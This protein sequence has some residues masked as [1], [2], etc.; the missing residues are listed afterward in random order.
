MIDQALRNKVMEMSLGGLSS[1]RT[2]SKPEKEHKEGKGGCPKCQECL[3]KGYNYCY[4][5][6]KKLSTKS[7]SYELPPLEKVL[8]S[9]LSRETTNEESDLDRLRKRVIRASRE[10]ASVVA[11]ILKGI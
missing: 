1:S 8:E 5:C 10:G 7:K 4:E 2:S 3:S 9:R 11:S 6:G